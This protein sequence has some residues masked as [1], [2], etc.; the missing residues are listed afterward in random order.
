MLPIRA[1]G[2]SET[3]RRDN[4]EDAFLLDEEH[5][6]FAVADGMGGHAAGEVASRQ[7]LES[8]RKSILGDWPR[9]RQIAAEGSARTGEVLRAAMTAAFRSACAEV[10]RLG[11]ED[12]RKS[13]M[14]TTCVA[15]LVTTGRVAI[16]HVGDSRVYLRRGGEV[17]QLTEDHSLLA[18]QVRRGMLSAEEAASAPGKNILL[19]IIGP[20]PDTQ[21]DTLIV[22]LQPGDGLL[23]CSDGVHGE[24]QAMELS[25][26]LGAP[27]PQ[28]AAAR[29]VEGALEQG[30]KDNATAVV[31][32]VGDASES[33][34]ATERCETLR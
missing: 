14:G 10:F 13:G 8:V 33:G 26:Y 30:G 11:Q 4:N 16:G 32:E 31:V 9:L 7:A 24:L 19:R 1:F 29:L 15:A 25:K 27:D 23:L 6:L 20:Q 3:G 21:V 17:H 28:A 34:D 22:E 12:L 2:R 5:G 18:E